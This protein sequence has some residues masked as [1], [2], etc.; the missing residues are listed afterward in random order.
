[1]FSPKRT[2][3]S[4]FLCRGLSSILLFDFSNFGSDYSTLAAAMSSR[5][6]AEF[7]RAM[8]VWPAGQQVRAEVTSF[9]GHSLASI[10]KRRASR[11]CV[12][13]ITRTNITTN[14]V[15]TYSRGGTECCGSGPGPKTQL[16]FFSGSVNA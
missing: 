8:R 1:M 14:S 4:G 6:H 12:G 15:A 10:G 9:R 13:K 16:M 5:F 3:A 2:R 11:R 7:H